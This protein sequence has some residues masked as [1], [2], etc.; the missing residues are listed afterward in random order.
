MYT[1]HIYCIHI[2][3]IYYLQGKLGDCWFLGALAVLAT[4]EKLLNNCFYRLSEFQ[5]FGVFICIFHKD[6]Q[7]IYVI[8]DDRIPVVSR[9]NKIVFARYGVRSICSL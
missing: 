7:L 1:Y 2:L 8:I 5:E 6:C 3:Y 4:N 9:T